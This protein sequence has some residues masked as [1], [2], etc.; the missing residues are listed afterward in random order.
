MPH[1]ESRLHNSIPHGTM[2]FSIGGHSLLRGSKFKSFD[3]VTKEGADKKNKTLTSF[4]FLIS[5]SF[6]RLS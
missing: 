2:R 4:N 1:K 6:I 3:S 5:F